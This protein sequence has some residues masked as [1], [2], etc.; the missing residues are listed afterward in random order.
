METQLV[1]S[2]VSGRPVWLTVDGR[3]ISCK[4]PGAKAKKEVLTVEELFEFFAERELPMPPKTRAQCAG[5][6]R[7][8]PYYCCRENLR[9]K[10]R[11]DGSVVI[12]PSDHPDS[13]ALD[14]AESGEELSL[15][16][17]GERLG[18]L[19]RERVRQIELAAI[20]K[21]RKKMPGWGIKGV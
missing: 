14:V 19:T 5:V 4:R 6:P 15:E 13:C 2:E 8:C 3:A 1:K 17:V 21:L 7:P 9:S 16:E 10:R 18:G 12:Y 20:A 11:A